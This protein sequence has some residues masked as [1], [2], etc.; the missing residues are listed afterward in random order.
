MHTGY[1]NVGRSGSVG[2]TLDEFQESSILYTH[3]LVAMYISCPNCTHTGICRDV[4]PKLHF[5]LPDASR[6]THA[7]STEYKSHS[8]V[9]YENG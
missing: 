1:G 7:L 3:T 8:Y 5:T 4:I 2:V 6:T 9:K